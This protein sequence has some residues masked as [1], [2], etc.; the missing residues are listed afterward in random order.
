MSKDVDRRG[1]QVAV[2]A[3]CELGERPVW[4]SR[5]RSLVWVDV[6]G[7]VLHRSVPP[8]DG[9][10]PWADRGLSVPAPVGAA[11]LRADGG[12]VLAAG[13]GLHQL[14][15]LGRPDVEPVPV[16][17]PP[18]ARFNDAA[19]DPVGRFLAGTTS[20]PGSPRSGVLWSLDPAGQV[21]PVLEGVQESNGL[22]WST[23]GAVLFYVDSGEPVVRRYA[24]DL[25]SG[26]VGQRLADLAVI[27]DGGGVP[28]G[29][30]VDADGAV[31]VALWE[32]GAVRRYSPDGL[33]LAHLEL[34]VSRPTCPALAGPGL[35]ILVVTSAW[36][37]MEAEARGA[38]PW[39]GHVLTTR[40]GATGRP[41][42]RFAAS[43]S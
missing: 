36:E 23:D 11:A 24:Y 40:V 6:L 5:T 17:V 37:G 1:W 35:G 10:G 18:G 15:R 22:D 34:P 7:G 41:P 14:D 30:V 16:D 13:S 20:P 19:C 39:A 3:G 27:S 4:D 33:L 28:D 21:R 9:P 2:A 12:L 42:H 25:A 32:G 43:P 29:L 38:E 26:R 8:E 31:W